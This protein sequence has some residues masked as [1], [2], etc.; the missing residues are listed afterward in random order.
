MACVQRALFLLITMTLTLCIHTDALFD[1]IGSSIASALLKEAL[2]PTTVSSTKMA[3]SEDFVKTLT[4]TQFDESVTIRHAQGVYASDLN[5]YA[6]DLKQIY[7]L[8]DE[9]T[10]EIK[11]LKYATQDNYMRRDF[12]YD[13]GGGYYRY[14]IVSAVRVNEKKIDIA[15]IHYNA[16]YKLTPIEVHHKTSKKFLFIKWG[17]K[18]HVTYRPRDLSEKDVQHLCNVLQ[19]RCHEAF[20]QMG[21]ATLLKAPPVDMIN[22]AKLDL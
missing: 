11:M 9:A 18:N 5:N 1:M 10:E 19:R 13:A 12:V 16:Q 8:P 14:M 17:T 7:K 20:Q 4:F 22:A 3:K 2:T 21:P 15:Y 6:M